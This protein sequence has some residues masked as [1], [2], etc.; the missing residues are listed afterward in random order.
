MQRI[1]E[2]ELIINSRGAIYHL[3]LR[4]EELANTVLTV[5]DPDRVAMVSKY[6]DKIEHQAQHR[7][8]AEHQPRG[9]LIAGVEP[10]R[11]GAMDVV[12]ERV[13]VGI[14]EGRERAHVGKA[15]VRHREAAAQSEAQPTGLAVGARRRGQCERAQR[16]ARKAQPGQSR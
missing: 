3:D 16:Q 12:G 1:A 6:F 8:A 2:S 13:R 4:P 14:A 11:D 9:E 5:G 7:V 15:T 10:D